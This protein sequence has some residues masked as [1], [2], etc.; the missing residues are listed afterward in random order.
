[1]AIKIEFERKSSNKELAS[2]YNYAGLQHFE[3]GQLTEA[4]QYYT[5]AVDIEKTN[6]M[7]LY[8]KAVA[9]SRVE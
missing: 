1:M 2:Y 7:Y 4:L 5:K 6:G 9:L 8:N 3:M